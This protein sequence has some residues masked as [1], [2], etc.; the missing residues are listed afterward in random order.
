MYI[1]KKQFLKGY[2]I[3]A[4]LISCFI[5]FISSCTEDEET[6]NKELAYR[7]APIHYQDADDEN[8]KGDYITKF[9]YDHTITTGDNWENMVSGDLSAY[10]YYSICETSTHWFIIYAY[11][12]PRDW[13]EGL[14]YGEHENDM[15]GVLLTV[16]KTNSKFG[17][18]QTMITTVHSDFYSYVLPNSTIQ[19]DH[20]QDIDGVISF[21]Y[22]NGFNHPITAQDARGHACYAYPYVKNFTDTTRGED[23]IVYK[24]SKIISETPSSG[25]DYS[26]FYKLIDMHDFGGLWMLQISQALTFKPT[27]LYASW[28]SLVGTSPGDNNAGT[29]W[30]WDDKDD[31]ETHAGEFA[32]SP[33]HLTAYYFKNLGEFS[34]IYIK[35]KYLTDLK[36]NGFNDNR[37]PAGISPGLSFT[38][39]YS[40]LA[41]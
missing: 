41:E 24:P 12:H 38:E 10:V 22:Y 27:E 21:S 9:D 1:K 18:L 17:E 23:G 20:G 14:F 40:K 13:D 11:Y 3:N 31:G 19:G 7:W 36:A 33:A 5:I 32:L 30:R 39:L 34:S 26:V 16:K 8:Y 4:F 15:E 25:L 28:G 29:P 35:N 2:R 6:F 37:R